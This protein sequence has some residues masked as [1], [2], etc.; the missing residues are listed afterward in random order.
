[1]VA[2]TS[3]HVGSAAGEGGRCRAVVGRASRSASS[4]ALSDRAQVHRYAAIRTFGFVGQSAVHSGV[5][6]LLCDVSVLVTRP[7]KAHDQPSMLPSPGSEKLSNVT[8][9]VAR[10]W[11][12]GV[13][14]SPNCVIDGSPFEPLVRSPRI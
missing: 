12:F 4:V 1:M 11:K 10:P 5:V 13:M 7:C 3:E 14:A 9:F 6:D 8:K 2:L